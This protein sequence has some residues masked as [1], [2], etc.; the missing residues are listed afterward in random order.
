MGTE[1]GRQMQR[2]TERGGGEWGRPVVC[3]GGLL[4]TRACCAVAS[5]D[6]LGVN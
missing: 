2:E 6:V 1:G 5:C 4:L 3:A